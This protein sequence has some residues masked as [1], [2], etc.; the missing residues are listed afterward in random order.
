MTMRVWKT[1]W[2][3]IA[4]AVVLMAQTAPPPPPPPQHPPPGGMDRRQRGLNALAGTWWTN[5]RLVQQLSLSDEQLRRIEAAFQRHKP[6]LASLTGELQQ[7]ESRLGVLLGADRRDEASVLAQVDRIAQ[8]RAEL[9]KANA[10]MLVGFRV[11]LTQEQWRKLQFEATR[12][13]PPPP[14][15]PGNAPPPPPR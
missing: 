8:A 13:I 4:G 1:F 2:L 6:V 9:E 15:P 7:Q 5:Q 10:R 14:K 12:S 3:G 11:V